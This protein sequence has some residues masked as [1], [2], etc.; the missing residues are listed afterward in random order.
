MLDHC[1]LHAVYNENG[2]MIGR[3]I[4]EIGD[5][6]SI[7]FAT[8]CSLEFLNFLKQAKTFWEA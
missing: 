4:V 1:Y 2:Y 7:S 8:K 3:M 6:G 5:K